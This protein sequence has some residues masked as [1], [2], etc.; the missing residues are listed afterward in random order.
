MAENAKNMRFYDWSHKDGETI[1]IEIIYQV[2]LNIFQNA[3]KQCQ[4]VSFDDNPKGT[5]E[6]PQT[7]SYYR[8]KRYRR[9]IRLTKLIRFSILFSQLKNQVRVLDLALP[10]V[11]ESS[12]SSVEI[13]LCNQI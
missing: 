12:P 10:Y 3:F 1:E 13:C 5:D 9:W 4:K 8:D 6:R 2:F 11:M 7:L